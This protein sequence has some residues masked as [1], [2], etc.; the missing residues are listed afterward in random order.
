[1]KLATKLNADRSPTRHLSFLEV[2]SKEGRDYI[3]A[4]RAAANFA[5]VN[6]QI[7]TAYVRANMRYYYPG[8]D[9]PI[10]YDVPHNM[11]KPEKHNGKMLWVH[12]KGATR[13]FPKSRMKG[14]VY[15]HLG[16]PVLIPG[17]MGTASYVLLGTETSNESLNSVNHGAGRVM[18]RSAAKGKRRKHKGGA[19]ER[20]GGVS[21]EAFEKAMEGIYLICADRKSI[22][23]EAPQAYKDID[24]VIEIVA[25]AG[26]AEP[27]ARLKPLAVMKG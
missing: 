10:I 25:G 11:A 27:V 12:R 1:M 24:V 3:K 6:R 22:Y 20:S 21:D 17:S 7:M 5:Y 23:E 16:Q 26:L 4:M 9:L 18:S 19:I 15:A 8:I 13:A 14:T 2:D